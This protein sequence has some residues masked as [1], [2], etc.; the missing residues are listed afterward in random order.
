[1]S[2]KTSDIEIAFSRLIGPLATVTKL[3]S[4]KEG[5]ERYKKLLDIV[6]KWS[7]D[8]TVTKDL[9]RINH[10]D[11]LNVYEEMEDLKTEFLFKDGIG[12]EGELSDEIVICMWQLMLYRK[13]QIESIK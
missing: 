9:S 11:L 10:V 2:V 3:P 12:I 4:Y 6:V 5:H 1:M 7:A 13:E 8:F